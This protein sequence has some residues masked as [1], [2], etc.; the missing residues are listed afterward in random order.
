M[1]PCW[2]QVCLPKPP[3]P[4]RST[5]PITD[6]SGGVV[7]AAAVTVKNTATEAERALTTNEA[8]IYVAQFLQPGSYEITVS[9]AG[10]AKIVR[11]GLTLQV[12][13]TLTMNFALARADHEE[14]VTVTG[15]AAIV[16]TEKTEM[17]QVVSQTQKENL[18]IAGPPLGRFRA[19]DAERHD[20]WR[21]GPGLLSRHFGAVQPELGG[22]HQQQPG[23]LLRNQGP[24]DSAL[25]LQH[26]FDPGIPGGV[27]QLQ[28]G[29]GTGGG[30]RDQ[31]G[32]QI[33]HEPLHGDLFYYL[34][35]P[36]L[37]ALDPLQKSRGIY[38]QPIHQQQQFGG[39]VGGPII[40]DKLFYFL[41]YDGSRKVNPISYTSTSFNGPQTLPGADS[42]G[43]CAAANGFVAAQL[44]AFPRATQSG[45]GASASWTTS[46]TRRNHL[47]ASFNGLNF[48]APNSYSTAT[49][50]NNE[51]LSAN[52][53]AV[54]HERIFVANWDSTIKPTLINSFRFQWSRDLEM[55]ARERHRAQRDRHQLHELRTAERAAASGVS[56][57]AP[58]AVLRRAFAEP[59]ARI[60]SRPAWT[61]T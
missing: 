39:S 54:T 53:T 3:A 13:Q 17:S 58:A 57:R 38:T 21:H 2:R 46:S 50:Q 52:G 28:R 20:R 30:R 56:G 40:K 33:R 11:T 61:S 44:G 16:D 12:G 43:H 48:Q 15:D 51:G 5:A 31:C 24:H 19:A 27:E 49:T 26:G 7:P 29:A 18:P 34:R 6:P 42:G 4:G 41:T 36:T 59:R 14:T 25:R 8:G 22:R 1:P 37:N 23:V 10:F 47:S 9:K 55:I 35:Y 45:R 60:P 32:D